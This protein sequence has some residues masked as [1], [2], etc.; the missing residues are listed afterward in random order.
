MIGDPKTAE[1]P[2]HYFSL[3]ILLILSPNILHSH[4]ARSARI[5]FGVDLPLPR[6]HLYLE[7]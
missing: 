1:L 2:S 7:Y 4:I 5:N 3:S 6:R